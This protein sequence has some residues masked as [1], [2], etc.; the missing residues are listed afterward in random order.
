MCEEIAQQHKG[1][2]YVAV[3]DAGYVL[4][5]WEEEDEK[6]EEGKLT[7]E[8]K[9]KRRRGRTIKK[10]RKGRITFYEYHL[11]F[12]SRKKNSILSNRFVIL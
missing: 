8:N 1:L 9:N 10:G 4:V 5:R 11:S 12:C 3:D 6:L 2:T 7:P